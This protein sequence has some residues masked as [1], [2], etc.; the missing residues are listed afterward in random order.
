MLTDEGNTS[1]YIGVNTMPDS[2]RTFKLSQSHL[3][4]KIINHVGPEVSTSVEAREMPTRI[5]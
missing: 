1:N 5:S 3:V 4:D 2:D